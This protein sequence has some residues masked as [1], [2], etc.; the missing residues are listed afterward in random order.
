MS[1]E[2]LVMDLALGD[3]YI[4]KPRT[5]SAGASLVVKHSAKQSEYLLYKKG[6]LEHYGMPCSL[7]SYEDKK[8]YSVLQ[9]RTSKNHIVRKVRDKLYVNGVKTLT[10]NNLSLFDSVSLA[11][12]YQDDGSREHAK[13][14]RC[15]GRK[16]AVKPYINQ[17]VLYVNNFSDT[18]VVNLLG[19]MLRLGVAGRAGKRKNYNVILVSRVAEKEKFAETVTPLL[20]YSMKY[21][22]DAPVRFYGVNDNLEAL[23]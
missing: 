13:W 6:L 20:H 21:K 1:I 3:G 5:D 19:A 15:D 17:F 12:L 23:T 8:G 16:Y 4:T 9:L 18:D 10:P 7:D 22:I 11:L 2:K 14:H